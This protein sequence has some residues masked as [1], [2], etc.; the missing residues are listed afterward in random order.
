MGTYDQR[1]DSVSSSKEMIAARGFRVVRGEGWSYN[2]QDGGEGTV[3]T[4]IHVRNDLQ[5]LLVTVIWDSGL[6]GFYEIDDKRPGTIVAHDA[7]QSGKSW[8][9]SIFF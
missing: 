7:R 4:I 6:K 5:R 2:D 8:L 9:L 1:G 3:G